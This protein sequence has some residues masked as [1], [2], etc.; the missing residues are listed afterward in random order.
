MIQIQSLLIFLFG[1]F[2]GLGVAAAISLFRK[3]ESS[4]LKEELRDTFSHLSLKALEQNADQFLKLA[5]ETL[6]QKSVL[7]NKECR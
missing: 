5:H 6:N 7:A 3:R 2:L 4:R 1:L